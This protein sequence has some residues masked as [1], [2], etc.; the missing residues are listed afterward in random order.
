MHKSYDWLRYKLFQPV[1]IASLVV[2]RILFGII[3]LV[4]VYLFF[5]HGRIKRFYIDPGFYFKYFGFEW[6]QPWSGDGMYWHFIALGILAF[7]ILVGLFYRV[8]TVLFFLA[9]SYVFLLDQTH[10][11]NHFYLV[12][13]ISFLLCFL[14]ANRAY[15]IDSKIWPQNR[16]E[17]IPA[18]AVWILVTQFEIMLLYAGLVKLNADW[19]QLQPLTMWFVERQDIFLIGPLITQKISIM[20]AA[21]GVIILHLVGAPLLLWRKTRSYIFILYLIFHLLNHI[22]WVIDIFPWLAIAGT[23]MFF[24]PDWPRR[25]NTWVNNKI[26]QLNLIIA[27]PT[28]FTSKKLQNNI[29]AKPISTDAALKQLLVIVLLAGWLL[30]QIIFPLRHYVYPGDVA[31]TEEGHRFSWRMKLRDKRGTVQFYTADTNNRQL[32]YIEINNLLFRNQ[33][34]QMACRP[35]MILQ[36]SHNLANALKEEKKIADPKIYVRSA[37]SLNGRKPAPLIDP[38]R[39]LAKVQ[40]NL[41]P[42]DWILPLHEPLPEWPGPVRIKKP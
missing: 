9:F 1:D 41:A 39:N 21:W 23:L 36:F 5:S 26:K 29:I 14:P 30:F 17:T 16:S 35:D 38:D 3:M 20:L 37:C 7:M 11:L 19:L 25:F 31:W 18:W 15:S 27:G 40:R 22:I 12:I 8:A 10:Y 4:E 33:I 28:I 13:L 2:F 32:W 6:V 34:T 42:A 24:S